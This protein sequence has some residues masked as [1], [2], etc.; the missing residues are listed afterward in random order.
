MS[1]EKQVIMASA[2]AFDTME[3]LGNLLSWLLTGVIIGDYASC[4]GESPTVEQFKKNTMN[5][6]KLSVDA[7]NLIFSII[8]AAEISAREGW[9]KY[10][11]K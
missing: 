9:E 8:E 1:A 2:S 4:N 6:E 5:A 3:A 7:K 10:G 11:D